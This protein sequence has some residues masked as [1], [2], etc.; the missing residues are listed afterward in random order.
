MLGNIKIGSAY[1]VEQ[2]NQFILTIDSAVF[3]CTSLE[4]ADKK[5][6][7]IVGPGASDYIAIIDTT[8]PEGRDEFQRRWE[9]LRENTRQA[10]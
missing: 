7:Q 9:A 3:D 6:Y 1:L 8:R 5:M 10:R 4:D 2:T